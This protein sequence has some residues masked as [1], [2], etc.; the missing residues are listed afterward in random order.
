MKTVREYKAEQKQITT[1]SDFGFSKETLVNKIPATALLKI[2]NY[3]NQQTF[4]DGFMIQAVAKMD[5]A[6][7]TGATQ[8]KVLIS[9]GFAG[10]CEISKMNPTKKIIFRY[11]VK[12][13]KVF[14]T[15]F[16]KYETTE[17]GFTKFLNEY[18]EQKIYTK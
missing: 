9:I 7:C 3:V 10:D 17:N 5:D 13:G 2:M 18:S 12:E 15:T 14:N 1:F 4:T 8:F 6:I 11:E 16:E